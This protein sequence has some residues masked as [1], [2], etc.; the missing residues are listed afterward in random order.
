MLTTEIP[1]MSGLAA[2]AVHVRG[3]RLFLAGMAGAHVL[4]LPCLVAF[5]L[6]SGAVGFGSAAVA[7]A[8]V[9]FFYGVGQWLVFRFSTSDPRTLFVIALGSFMGRSLLLGAALMAASSLVDA[10]RL[11]PTALVVTAAAALV[12]W[13]TCEILV[14]SRL[15]IPAFDL[16]HEVGVAPV[17]LSEAGV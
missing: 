5:G 9:L 1:P 17:A 4:G 6:I 15:R 8:L 7:L 2:R 13:L 14:W 11:D 3:R 16:D 12:G 10:T